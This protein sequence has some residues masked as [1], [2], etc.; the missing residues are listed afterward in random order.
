MD[1]FESVI[2]TLLEHKGYW[3][4]TGFKV[5]LT[6]D[7]KKQIGKPTCP[8]W[9]IDVIAYQGKTNTLLV[10]ECKSYL[11]SSGVRLSS[12]DSS[13]DRHAD[14][15][16]LFNDCVL[17]QVVFNRLSLQLVEA[18]LCAS[19]PQMKLCLAAGKIYQDVKLIREHFNKNG[20]ELWEPED[21]R[22]DIEAL[23]DS[24]YENTII[25]IVAKML[26]RNK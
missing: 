5:E 15:Y 17:K 19:S 1:A 6:K 18:G 14:G 24:G 7:E 22:K 21:I 3:T 2:A 26:L 10:Y 4:R 20:W 8:R 25:A 23:V 12:F 13:N 9:E 11:D 16:K